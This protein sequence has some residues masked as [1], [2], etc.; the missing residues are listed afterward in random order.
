MPGSS[1]CNG[2]LCLCAVNCGHLLSAVPMPWERPRA[3][4]ELGGGRPPRHSPLGGGRAL[5]K[6]RSS[7]RASNSAPFRLILTIC[8]PLL[9]SLQPSSCSA[10]VTSRVHRPPRACCTTPLTPR[11]QPPPGTP[12]SRIFVAMVAAGSSVRTCDLFG[13][14]ASGVASDRLGVNHYITA[15]ASRGSASRGLGAHG[16]W[17]WDVT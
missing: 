9:P 17:S 4:I 8:L 7:P 14:I 2:H 6:V 11:P 16:G 5:Q 10:D 1:S 3:V 12:L 13:A 15:T